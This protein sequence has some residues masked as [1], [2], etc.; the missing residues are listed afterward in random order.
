MYNN[1]CHDQYYGTLIPK[2]YS[3]AAKWCRRDAE[4]G[5][6]MGMTLLSLMY[7][8]GK[9]LPKDDVQSYMWANLAGATDKNAANLREAL[10]RVMTAEQIAQAQE[11]SRNFRPKTLE[12]NHR[13][14]SEQSVSTSTS[15]TTSGIHQ[16]EGGDAE[17]AIDRIRRGKH[18]SMPKAERAPATVSGS[19]GITLENGTNYTIRVY[20]GGPASRT[21]TIAPRSSTKV[22]LGVGLYREAAEV[23]SSTILP[24]YGY[25]YQERN[26][27]YHVKF[28]VTH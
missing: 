19:G 17:A 7:S 12:A 3:E 20:F 13:L 14:A 28:Y 5:G 27:D 6:N 25:H 2:N 18:S 16:I 23:L 11:L 8:D 9:G 1:L 15:T 21:I 24:F 26:A 22:D 10:A 4:I